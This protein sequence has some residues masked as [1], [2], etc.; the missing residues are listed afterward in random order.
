M[1]FGSKDLSA[2]SA[3]TNAHASD[4]YKVPQS[5]AI[6]LN[7]AAE[8]PKNFYEQIYDTNKWSHTCHK[9]EGKEIQ[10]K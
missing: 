7:V 6:Q 8:A 4:T 1:N 9:E 10:T 3:M 2:Y 5:S